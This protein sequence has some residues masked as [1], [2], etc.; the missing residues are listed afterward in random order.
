MKIWKTTKYWSNEHTVLDFNST[1]LNLLSSI[2]LNKVSLCPKQLKCS[3]TMLKSVSQKNENH[4]SIKL[5]SGHSKQC[6]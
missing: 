2:I 3:E 5:I 1:E 4:Q 6:E